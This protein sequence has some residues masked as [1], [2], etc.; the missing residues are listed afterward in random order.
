M[1]LS[2]VCLIHCLIIKL[3]GFGSQAHVCVTFLSADSENKTS[4]YAHS[5]IRIYFCDKLSICEAFPLSWLVLIQYRH[6]RSHQL[7]K[8]SVPVQYSITIFIIHG[9]YNLI[10]QAL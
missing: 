5:W 3:Y 7:Q 2:T 8:Q 1:P 4:I 6:V 9:D 10:H